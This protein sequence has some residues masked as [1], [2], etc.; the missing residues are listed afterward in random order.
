MA[1]IPTPKK[2]ILE[3]RGK[4]S[5]LLLADPAYGHNVYAVKYPRDEESSVTI[6]SQFI[7]KTEAVAEFERMAHY[8]ETRG[9]TK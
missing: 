1:K 2:T 8:F 3:R 6:T 5:L 7:I 4:V 9:I